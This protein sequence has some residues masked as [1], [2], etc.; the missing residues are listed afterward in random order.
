MQNFRSDVLT[1]S[2]ILSNVS[3][4]KLL[5]KQNTYGLLEKSV[6]LSWKINFSGNLFEIFYNK[7]LIITLWM[8]MQIYIFI[9]RVKGMEFK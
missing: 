6:T 5:L 2:A 4:I 9:N 3:R 7:Q 8:S 1:V